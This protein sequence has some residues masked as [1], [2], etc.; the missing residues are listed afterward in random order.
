[1]PGDVLRWGVLGS[2]KIAEIAFA[3][4]LRSVPGCVLTAVASRNEDRARAF[5]GVV[6]AA[7][8]YA[9]YEALLED[10]SVD[11]VYIALP[12]SMHSEWAVRALRAGKHVL[13][14]K[15]MATTAAEAAA[16]ADAADESGR[17]LMEGFMYRFH[18]RT[19]RV[20]QLIAAG[21]IGQVRTI[22]ATYSFQ[23]AAA[24]DVRS[25]TVDADI[26]SQRHLGGG[27]LYDVGSYCVN[28]IR[29]YSGKEPRRV[30]GWSSRDGHA[31]V[32]LRAGGILDFGDGT[33]GDFFCSMDTF[34]GG[35]VE[36]YG[37]EGK[38]SIPIAFRVRPTDP[39]PSVTIATREGSVVETFDH[40][41][42]YRLE[43]EA[44]V[45]ALSGERPPLAVA[46]SVANAAVLD[47]LR[48]SMARTERNGSGSGGAW[49]D[50]ANHAGATERRSHGGAVR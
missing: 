33:S 6:G 17:L 50:V 29:F 22:R 48:E 21:A 41:D 15:P 3:P 34:G 5:A 46:D 26:R 1:M 20:R 42:Q 27:A 10:A 43:I 23:L 9:P 14:E 18:P 35:Q 4:A 45:S 37:S 2:A 16:M 19:G 7:R 38:L 39:A 24:T 31:D 12:N 36:V 8:A 47:A 40:D 32:E 49:V 13:C 30:V 28:A 25:S 11:C 44:F